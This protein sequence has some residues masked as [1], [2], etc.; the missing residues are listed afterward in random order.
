MPIDIVFGAGGIGSS[1]FAHTWT[2]PE[3][4]S[5]LL[6]VL[7]QLDIR[8]LDSAATYPPGNPWHT[9]TL[10]GETK[11]AERGFIIDSKAMVEREGPSLH[12]AGI[13]SSIDKTLDLLGTKTVRI[14]YAH[15]S[16][17]VTPLKETAAS[18]DRQFKE[19]KF[20]KVRQPAPRLQNVL[21]AL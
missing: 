16:D 20:E 4:V 15:V 9:E 5:Q 3:E 11:A 7:E 13:T 1:H 8:A 18:F 2:T 14:F 6:D 21:E 19:G 12:D 17:P 10:L